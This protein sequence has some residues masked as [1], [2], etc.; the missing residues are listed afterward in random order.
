M[1]ND[2]VR[3]VGLLQ[4]LNS[5][6]YE[7]RSVV[8]DGD[9][10]SKQRAR[11]G[12]GRRVYTPTAL[13]VAT[14]A[15]KHQLRAFDLPVLDGNVAVACVFYRSTRQRIDTDNLTKFILDAGNGIC[16]HD[17]VQ[18]T[19]LTAVLEHDPERPRTVLGLAR[20]ETSMVRGI[21][22]WVP[23]AHCGEAFDPKSQ[24]IKYCSPTC[25]TTARGVDLTTP[26]P[27]LHCGEPFR[28]RT[29]SMKLCSEVCRR[30]W[31]RGRHRARRVEHL[32][33]DCGKPVSK[34]GYRRCRECWRAAA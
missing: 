17:D 8:I 19:A 1:G 25:R 26:V 16:W 18:V 7:S 6:M 23:C 12:R 27:C 33:V 22:A 20:H 14:D 2:H 29:T 21:D 9:P 28:R 15:M 30:E 34:A 13:R 10:T 3:V 31:L 5:D 4:A 11:V 32:C 24:P